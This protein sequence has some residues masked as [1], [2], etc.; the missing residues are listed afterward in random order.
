MHAL[1]TLRLLFCVYLIICLICRWVFKQNWYPV[2]LIDLP[3]LTASC[4]LAFHM[5]LVHTFCGLSFFD[6]VIYKLF[7][8]NR[9]QFHF[10]SYV[11]WAYWSTR[12]AEKWIEV[13]CDKIGIPSA[14]LNPN[15]F[16]W[17]RLES[18]TRIT[19]NLL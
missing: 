5:F 2:T 10:V 6:V 19:I 4:F 1:F 15:H 9:K 17:K 13:I 8:W 7:G 11:F 18:N 12:S 16:K 14:I 3:P